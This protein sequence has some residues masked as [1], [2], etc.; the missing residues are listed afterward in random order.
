VKLPVP[1][2]PKVE[3]DKLPT[4]DAI[5]WHRG[6]ANA[7]VVHTKPPRTERKRHLRKYAEGNLGPERSFY[8]RG[9]EGKLNLRAGNLQLFLQLAEGVDDDTWEFHRKNGDFSHWV[10]FQIKDVSLAEE[11][12]E[13][14]SNEKAKP[15]DSRAAVR[16]AIEA[17]YTLPA[18][19][20]SGIVD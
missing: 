9:P 13:V 16:A 20:A 11:L 17:R 8:F 5:V 4:G 3:G 10:R 1:A 18:E 6:E 2:C 15:H 19:T 12:S 7:I 14:E